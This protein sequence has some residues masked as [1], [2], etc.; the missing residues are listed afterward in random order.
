MKNLHAI[1]FHPY[2]RSANIEK[3]GEFKQIPANKERTKKAGRAVIVFNTKFNGTKR[4]PVRTKSE[5]VYAF[6]AIQYIK[7]S[8]LAKNVKVKIEVIKT[9]KPLKFKMKRI[10]RIMRT[11]G[12]GSFKMVWKVTNNHNDVVK[13]FVTK[14]K[15]TDFVRTQKNSK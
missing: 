11:N 6:K 2:Y 13:Y 10:R 12:V 14:V 8:K 4:I 9:P 7:S 15:A 5:M 1:E 3:C